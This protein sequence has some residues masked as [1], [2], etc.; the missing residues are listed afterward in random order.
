[1][2]CTNRGYIECLNKYNYV[3]V[4]FI[5]GINVDI[6]PH[7]QFCQVP[8]VEGIVS[9]SGHLLNISSATNQGTLLRISVQSTQSEEEESGRGEGW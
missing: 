6:V 3:T 7:N 4:L 8:I 1:M 5:F 9:Q 2:R